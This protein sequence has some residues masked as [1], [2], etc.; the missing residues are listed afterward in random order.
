MQ[1]ELNACCWRIA[2][3]WP[4]DTDCSTDPLCYITLLLPLTAGGSTTSCSSSSSNT[5]STTSSYCILWER[6]RRWRRCGYRPIR[7]VD[8]E[9]KG[10]ERRDAKQSPHCHPS[11]PRPPLCTL[12]ALLLYHRAYLFYYPLLN[13]RQRGAVVEFTHMIQFKLTWKARQNYFLFYPHS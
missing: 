2:G 4:T 12:L 6:R 5:T 10:L 7:S 3:K 11:C 9:R 8:S 1:T 13:I